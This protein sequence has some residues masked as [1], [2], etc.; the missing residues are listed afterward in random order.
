MTVTVVRETHFPEL[1]LANRG[2][3]R[4][5]YDL[6]DTLLIVTTDRMSAF[7]VV[8]DDPIPDKGKVLNK[9]SLFWFEKTSSIIENHVITANPD[10]YPEVCWPYREYLEDRSMLVIKAKPLPVECVVRGYISGSGWRE[11]QEKGSISGVALPDGLKESS[12]LPESIFTPSTKAEVGLHDE[13]ISIDE[14]VRLVGEDVPGAIKRISLEIYEFGMEL[15]AGKGIIIADTKFEFGYKNGSLIL[16]DEVL[17][18][19]SS[20]F[21]PMDEYEPGRAQRSFDK[22]FLRDYLDG[23]DWPKKPPPPK[24]PEEV[25]N[26]TRDKYLEALQRITGRGL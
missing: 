15:A 26:I 19:D 11:Y 24:L 23:L 20:R 10:E 2:K 4:D 1:K 9:I 3:V 12:K 14:V 13:N 8:M 16:I 22:Q 5:I 21:W 18:P 6:G 25:I 17:T 7:D